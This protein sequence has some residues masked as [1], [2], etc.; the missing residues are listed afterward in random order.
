MKNGYQKAVF[1]GGVLLLLLIIVWALQVDVVYARQS[2]FSPSSSSYG[3]S[4]GVDYSSSIMTPY[5][6]TRLLQSALYGLLGALL[7]ALCTHAAKPV[8]QGLLAIAVLLGLFVGIN[9]VQILADIILFGFGAIVAYILMNK[10]YPQPS[11][12]KPTIFGSA[13]WASLDHL[14]QH[15]LVG[16]N[17][18]SLGVFEEKTDPNNR[19]QNT[20]LPPTI[21]DHPLHYTGDRHLL[22]VAPTRAG[23][24]VSTIIPNLLMYQGSALVID[25]K[26]ENAMIT[27]PRRGSGDAER[28]IQGLGQTVHVVDPWGISHL[29]ASCF[30]P[31]DWLR[32]DDPDINE[33]AMILAD[34]IVSPHVGSNDS[35]W[36]EEAKALLMGILLYVALDNDE[37]DKRT[38]GRVRDIISM[39]QADLDEYLKLMEA[40]P[41]RIIRGSAS[42]TRAKEQRLQ[43]SVLASLQSHTHFLDSPS[44]RHSLSVSDFNFEDLKTS[45]M[46]IYLVLPADRMNTFGRWLRLLVQQALTVNAR[47]IEK[48]PERPVLFLLDE[49]A[50]LG[51]LSMVEQAYGLMAGFGVQLWGIVQDLSQLQ[52][53]YGD[54][55]QTFIG[56]SGVIQYFGSRDLMTAEYFSKLCGVTTVEKKS[57]SQAIAKAISSS[58]GNNSSSTTRT[59]TISDDIAQR[60][61]IYPDELMV[62]RDDKT[63]VFVESYNPIPAKKI[64][65]YKD[66]DLKRHGVNLHA[67][68]T[69]ASEG[70]SWTRGMSGKQQ[71]A[72]DQNDQGETL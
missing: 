25:P 47:N 67:R 48:K 62:M 49:M 38:L 44:I 58:V 55:W 1:C 40:H 59:E 71:E 20:T 19:T 33:N 66:D 61:L 50:T 5:W 68:Q 69:S 22:T 53:I 64:T 60:S 41:N 26:G 63:L 9:Y 23:K 10:W 45:R 34:A 36:D 57:F 30:N 28:G 17:G 15:E 43:S 6:V 42:R 14:V 29:P 27:A 70:H 13:T 51:R 56:N 37:Q 46:T 2:I 7:G 18:F 4:P 31:L 72:T 54:G 12:P 52:R 39:N 65:W 8:R 11:P 21:I 16:K 3:G 24:G 32:P 35:F